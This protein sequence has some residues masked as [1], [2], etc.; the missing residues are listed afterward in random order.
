MRRLLPAFVIS[1]IVWHCAGVLTQAQLV[2]VGPGFVKAPFVRVYHDPSGGSHVRAPFV[3]VYTPGMRVAPVIRNAPPDI[4][5]SRMDWRSLDRAVQDWSSRLD[6][7]LNGIPSGEFWK[8]SLKIKDIA[9][10]VP[11]DRDGP[12]PEE[13]RRN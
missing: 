5:L 12:P 7:D 6:T 8:S 9:R 2:Q 3:D 4:E 1:M 13:V 11:S 10:L